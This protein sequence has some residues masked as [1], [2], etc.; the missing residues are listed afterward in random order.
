M[1][2]VRGTKIMKERKKGKKS[3]A[4]LVILVFSILSVEA[5]NLLF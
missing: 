4:E 2:E 3:H 5:G 1:Y